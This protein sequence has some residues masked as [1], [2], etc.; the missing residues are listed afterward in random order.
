LAF[1]FSEKDQRKSVLLVDLGAPGDISVQR[2]ATPVPRPLTEL[3]GTLEE[4]L[5]RAD[6]HGQ[7]WIKAVVTDPHRPPHLIERLRATYPQLLH[8]EHRPVGREHAAT[9]PAV[10]RESDPMEIMGEF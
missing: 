6:Q 1:S 5:A 10:R 7:D 9:A 2:I 4:I 8:T 3:H